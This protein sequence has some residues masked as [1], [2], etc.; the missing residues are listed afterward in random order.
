MRKALKYFWTHQRPA[1]IVAVAGLILAGYFAFGF[2]AEVIY[3]NDPR[4]QNQAL[5]PWMT[6]RYVS[7]SYRIPPEILTDALGYAGE[8][9]GR[10]RVTE[11]A[12]ETGMT[13]EEMQSRIAEA[14][15]ALEAER[16]ARR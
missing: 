13:L 2:L 8:L 10:L 3:F 6:L 12:E 7:L 11:V 1:L 16:G 5:Q 14:Q 4:H 15:A 9:G